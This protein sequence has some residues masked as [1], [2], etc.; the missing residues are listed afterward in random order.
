MIEWSWRIEGK[1]RIWCGSWSDGARW[2]RAFARLEGK[3]VASISLTGRLP[4]ITVA[5]S[6]GLYISSI[7]TAEGNPAWTLTRSHDSASMNVV[8]GRLRLTEEEG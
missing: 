5:L 6:N 7:M 2:P 3:T 4:E 1:R 8:A